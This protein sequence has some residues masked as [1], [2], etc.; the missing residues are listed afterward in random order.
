MSVELVPW[1]YGRIKVTGRVK[2]RWYGD[3]A[4]AHHVEVVAKLKSLA[5]IGAAVASARLAAHVGGAS[6]P[7]DYEPRIHRTG[8][9]LDEYIWLEVTPHRVAPGR[10]ITKRRDREERRAMGAVY[11]IEYGNRKAG[12]RGIGPLW[13]ASQALRGG[14]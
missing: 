12:W 5:D 4:A 3:V 1:R 13:A 11:A 14:L 10:G 8:R 6:K 2:S 7:G 9:A